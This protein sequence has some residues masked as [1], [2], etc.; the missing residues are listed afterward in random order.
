MTSTL[1]FAFLW[2]AAGVLIGSPYWLALRWSAGVLAAGRS[3]ALA[4]AVQLVRF[5]ALGAALTFVTIH[6]GAVALLF[7]AGGL[8]LAR[9]VALCRVARG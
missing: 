9:A 4:I 7:S 5:A 1:H 3:I 8:M 2:L 6:W